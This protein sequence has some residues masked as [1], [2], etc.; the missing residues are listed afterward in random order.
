[1]ARLPPLPFKSQLI[2]PDGL[3]TQWWA[4]WLEKVI[5]RNTETVSTERLDDQA[6]TFAKI[7]NIASDRLIGRDTASSG[8][9][10]EISVG[11]GVEFSG[12]GGIQTAAF[13]GDVTKAAGGTA[14]T[15]PAGSIAFAKML[16]T[17]WTKDTSNTGYTKLPNGI[18]MQWGFMTNI[19]SGSTGTALFSVAF[20]TAVRTIQCT[21]Q[22]NSAVATT[23]TGQVGFGNVSTTSFDIYNRT[24]VTHNVYWLAVGY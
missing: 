9:P 18:Y 1:M 8:V 24:S 20:P 15:I 14:L 2:G 3:I 4:D 10:E 21:P 17:D 19:T 12:S 7:Q 13:T 11:G 22:G 16:A 5:K 6:V 23:A